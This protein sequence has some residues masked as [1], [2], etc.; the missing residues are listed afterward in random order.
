MTNLYDFGPIIEQ[1]F[2]NWTA[3]NIFLNCKINY[4]NS[5]AVD[6]G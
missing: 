6:M 2:E 4:L 5:K 3:L 1:P